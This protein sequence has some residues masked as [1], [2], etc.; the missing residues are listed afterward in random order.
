MRKWFK[1][2]TLAPVSVLPVSAIAC[3]RVE[4]TEEKI[5]Q[6]ALFK[7]SEVSTIA[8]NLW[9]DSTLK[10]LY[11]VETNLTDNEAFLNDAYQAY[12][13]YLAKQYTDGST[14]ALYLSTQLN[15]WQTEGIFTPE[16]LEVLKSLA[17]TIYKT[18]LT[19]EQFTVLY[20]T[21]KTG[22]KLIVNKVLLVNKY[23][24]INDKDKLLKTEASAFALYGDKFDLDDF[25]LISYVINKRL[26]QLWQYDSSN[27]VDVFSTAQTSISN[28]SDYISLIQN[29]N[30]A[31]TIPTEAL[32]INTN[33]SYE[34]TMG[35]YKGLQSDN[36]NNDY[37]V[38]TLL[39][40]TNDD[41][42]IGFYNPITKQM[43]KV[44][45]DGVVASAVPVSNNNANISVIYLSQI[46][47]VG[48]KETVTENGTENTKTKLSF[49][50]TPYAN[51]L[52]KLRLLAAVYDDAL[53]KKAES[54]FVKLGY[55]LKVDIEDIKKQLEN[56]EFVAK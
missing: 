14:G 11:N 52:N 41:I 4:D 34:L 43:V 38:D 12:Q 48:K 24:Q 28:V 42:L 33:A 8:Q 32:L 55:V 23:F 2:L 45:S 3:G 40:K 37:S 19:K 7:N 53:Y 30:V 35:G 13:S 20:N 17:S 46:K 26:V 31:E 1:F 25:N 21:E 49:K 51:N 27:P 10:A 9:L 16:Q 56:P 50:E 6:D 5:K 54:T 47:P 36:L 18:P 29:S 15:K 22:V 39:T 44:N